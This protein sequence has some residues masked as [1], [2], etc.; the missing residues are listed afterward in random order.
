MLPFTATLT[1][2]PIFGPLIGAL[3]C[4]WSREERVEWWRSILKWRVRPSILATA[5]LLAPVLFFSAVRAATAFVGATPIRLPQLATIATVSLGMFLTAGVG[6]EPGWRGFLLPELRKSMGAVAA[7]AVVAVTWFAW[8]VPL[9]W[10]AG[11]S[12][13][14]MPFAA[15]A[16]GLASYSFITTWL[17]EAS[18]GSTLVAMLFHAAANVTFWVAMVTTK[19][20]P[21]ERFVTAM[22]VVSLIVVA[23]AAAAS[24]SLSERKR[25]FRTRSS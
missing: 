13:S 12:Q 23:I 5:C 21:Q 6:E 2:L 7:S 9:F 8:H 11:S 22:Y 19:A 16:L 25:R 14:D 4:L 3:S 20:T 10:I 1:A 24:L 18:A 15:F 17:V